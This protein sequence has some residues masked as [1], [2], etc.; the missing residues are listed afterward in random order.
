MTRFKTVYIFFRDVGI[1]KQGLTNY[2]EHRLTHAFHFFEKRKDMV[3][4]VLMARRG[5]YQRPFMHFSVGVLFVAGLVSGPIL[6]DTYPGRNPASDLEN[7]TP[8]SAVATSLDF[9]EYGVKTQVSEKPRDQV[10]EYTVEQ[11]DTLS[12]IATKFG[13]SL[14]TIRW[15]NSLSRDV[16]QVGQVL[17][18]PPVTGVVH[19]VREGETVYSIAKRYSTEAQ[20]IV[21]FPFNDFSD[22]DTFALNVGQTL[23]VPDGEIAQPVS[24]PVIPS[25]IAVNT[26]SNLS[27]G[28]SGQFSWPTG[29]VITQYPIWYHM[30][31][32]IANREAPAITAAGE[33]TVASVQF[34]KY[35][36]GQHII[37]S[38]TEGLS[39]L[40]AHM[41][42]IYVK[43]GDKVTRGQVLGRMGSTGRSTGTHLHF[44]VRRNGT[45]VDPRPFLK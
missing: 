40:Y 19:K 22:L 36:Y 39:T 25:R 37:I 7:F 10:L 45:P 2:I 15:A 23:V 6:A 38:H 43:A 5:K 44:E 28:G 24:K 12:S 18:I 16:L 32:D 35:G 41:S 20:K 13:I 42:E 30:A 1:F 31:L 11:G 8:P 14:D 27:S 34:L 21:N 17:K 9:S 3:V 4:D 29:G 33:G 26:P